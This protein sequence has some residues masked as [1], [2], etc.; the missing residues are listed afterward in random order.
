[1]SPDY[2]LTSWLIFLPGIEDL[3]KNLRIAFANSV[4]KLKKDYVPS[5]TDSYAVEITVDEEPINLCLWDTMGLEDQERYRVSTYAQTDVFVLIYNVNNMASFEYL[6]DTVYPEV[7]R[8]ATGAPI[9]IVGHTSEP[10]ARK[11]VT[12]DTVKADPRIKGTRYQEYCS[13]TEKGLKQI[14]D[15]AV[16]AHNESGRKATTEEAPQ[17]SGSMFGA[18]T[19]AIS[20]STHSFYIVCGYFC[21]QKI[22]MIGSRAKT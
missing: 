6:R 15:E 5:E 18:F 11:L 3:S 1:M 16:R 17:R 8:Y 22:G 9:I 7:Q 19:G 13:F 2:L 4:N 10:F 14:F 12:M 21:A 20:V